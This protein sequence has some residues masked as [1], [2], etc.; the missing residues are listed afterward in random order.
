L[1]KIIISLL[2]VAIITIGVNEVSA[3][4]LTEPIDVQS[5]TAFENI[6]DQGSNVN[7]IFSVRYNM[8]Q[9]SW[10]PFLKDQTGCE[11]QTPSTTI[12]CSFPETLSSS[13]ATIGLYKH[14]LSS[15]ITDTIVSNASYGSDFTEPVR[16]IGNTLFG[17][18]I[19]GNA[20]TGL[21]TGIDK[22]LD[23]LI[24]DGSV[25]CI[26]SYNV[27][28]PII[29]QQNYSCADIKDL[30]NISTKNIGTQKERLIKHIQD[31]LQD[32]TIDESLPDNTLINQNAKVT[33][34]GVIITRRVSPLLQQVL[35]ELFDVGLTDLVDV[36]PV[37]ATSTL[38]TTLQTE[39]E[40]QDIYSAAVMVGKQ[41][42]G[43]EAPVFLSFTLILVAII[44]GAGMYLLSGNSI[45][46]IVFGF[47]GT[48]V[49]A[50][51][52]APPLLQ[53]LLV[54]MFVGL[55]GMVIY[56]VRKIPS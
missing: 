55:I 5:V 26:V 48:L 19:S 52:I 43:M 16:V 27:F 36:P 10:Y 14:A 44:T 20:E 4:T 3:D 9:S 1:K 17:L 8:S 35:P 22:T 28:T 29:P 56:L 42:F 34:N 13:I 38:E 21:I 25:V 53:P 12:L 18:N 54:G 33:G 39:L 45:F 11:S 41:Y 7:F 50:V 37:F 46:G 40:T 49:T 51:F 2:T 23:Q 24:E 31:N 6:Y 15:T 32:I 47:A 30:P